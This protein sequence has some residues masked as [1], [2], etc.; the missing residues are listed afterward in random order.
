VTGTQ[1]LKE[2][3]AIEC[4]VFN[5]LMP[6]KDCSKVRG[7]IK[8]QALK[9][10]VNREKV[11]LSNYDPCCGC[12]YEKEPDEIISKVQ[13]GGRYKINPMEDLDV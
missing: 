1:W 9:H 4:P 7:R 10:Y 6:E 8:N 11:I 2:N 5:C 13:L 3:G 12:Q